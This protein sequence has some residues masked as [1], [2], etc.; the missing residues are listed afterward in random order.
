[1]DMN[2]IIHLQCYSMMYAHMNTTLHAATYSKNIIEIYASR[3]EFYIPIEEKLIITFQAYTI[4]CK[5]LNITAFPIA[6]I[7]T[8]NMKRQY[9][10]V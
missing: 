4:C 2:N 3:T 6:N 9:M 1:M 8:R 5:N 7:S 10:H